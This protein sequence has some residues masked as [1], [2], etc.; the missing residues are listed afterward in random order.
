[1][2]LRVGDLM[3]A[4]VRVEWLGELRFKG[5]NSHGKSAIMDA[6][7]VEGRPAGVTPMQLLLM[8][9]GGCTGIDIVSILR[10]QRQNLTGFA[11]NITGH[12]RSEP[13]KYYERIHVEYVLRGSGLD[14]KKVRRAILLSEEKYCSV[15]A[16]LIDKAQ[17]TSSYRVEA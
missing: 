16:M 11:V 2:I 1:M 6:T 3:E 13:P 8:A 4:K 10:K 15:R 7:D 14:D 17:V 9:L 5:T 12:R